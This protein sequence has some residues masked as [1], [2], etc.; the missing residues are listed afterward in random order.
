VSVAVCIAG[1]AALAI[2]PVDKFNLDDWERSSVRTYLAIRAVLAASAGLYG[3]V[4]FWNGPVLMKGT[5]L[6][7]LIAFVLCMTFSVVK[8]LVS[9]RFNVDTSRAPSFLLSDCVS[10]TIFFALLL[11]TQLFLIDAAAA[12]NTQSYYHQF[13]HYMFSVGYFCTF[14]FVCGRRACGYTK[15]DALGC[16]V[17]GWRSRAALD[18]LLAL[19]FGIG[20]SF[21]FEGV[22]AFSFTSF[23]FCSPSCVNTAEVLSFRTAFEMASR[24]AFYFAVWSPVLLLFGSLQFNSV[25]MLLFRVLAEWWGMEGVI[26]RQRAGAQLAAATNILVCDTQTKVYWIKRKNENKALCGQPNC[27]RRD[28][29]MPGH[30]DEDSIENKSTIEGKEV[31]ACRIFAVRIYYR[32]DTAKEW[33]AHFDGPC[34]VFSGGAYNILNPPASVSSESDEDVYAWRDDNFDTDTPVRRDGSH[35]PYVLIK[36]QEQKAKQLDIARDTQQ[37]PRDDDAEDKDNH[38]LDWARTHFR[39]FALP[40]ADTFKGMLEVSPRHAKEK[41]F[42]GSCQSVF[43]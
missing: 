27:I 17:K 36:G 1:A 5:V 43:A 26:V 38:Y 11:L 20:A 16:E 3:L 29:W 31:T 14:L 9:G 42:T 32:E 13:D 35:G 37:Q 30:I 4:Y 28:H 23:S 10:G 41:N 12:V 7:P 2:I 21:L 25:R 15:V 6:A 24:I 19:L 8:D 33:S 34:V 18:T 40:S 22:A 39:A